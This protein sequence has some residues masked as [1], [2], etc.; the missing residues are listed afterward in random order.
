MRA[1]THAVG[2]YTVIVRKGKVLIMIL[3]YEVSLSSLLSEIDA[4]PVSP[5]PKFLLLMLLLVLF[6][7]GIDDANTSAM[8]LGVAAILTEIFFVLLL[9]LE[10]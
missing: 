4:P 2:M 8:V 6:N 1:P 10:T 3:L 9:Q 5:F 7:D